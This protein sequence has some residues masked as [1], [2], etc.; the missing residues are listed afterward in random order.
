MVFSW[1]MT[2]VELRTQLYKLLTLF[3]LMVLCAGAQSDTITLV[4][5]SFESGSTGWSGA[6]TDNSE[7]YAAPDGI[8]Y[9]TCSGGSGYTTQLTGHTIEAGETFTLTVWARSIN[10]RGV[11]ADTNAEVRLFY[12]STTITSTTQNVNPAELQG[13]PQNYFN[14]DGGN[15]WLDA[16]YRMEFGARYPFY[17]LDTA[18][19]IDDTWYHQVDSDYDVDMAVGPIITPQ[20]LKALYNTYYEESP[21]PYSQI[22]ILNATGSPPNYTWTPGSTILEHEGSENPWCIDAH[23]YYDTDTGKLWM[24]WGGLPL[25]VSEMDPSDG[26]LIGHP[27]NPE[28]DTHP[29]WYHT[30]VANWSGD[31]WTA[32][33]KWAEG[34][35]LYKHDGY[36]Y[37]LASY[38]NL[39]LNYSI[40][41]GRGTS[42]TGPFYDKEGVGLLEWDSSENEY[43]NSFLLG[44]EGFQD[45]PGHPHIWEENGT[46]YLGYDYTIGEEQDVLGIRELYWVN[47]WPTIW[48]PITITFDVGDYPASIGQQL[49]ISFRNTGS[50]SYAA[51]DHV[52]IEYT[53]ADS[54]PPAP[55]PMTWAQEP[56]ADDS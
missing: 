3:V 33:N 40:R 23:L 41:G 17:Q 46:Y 56:T 42:P 55:D 38:G 1:T 54:T 22:W 12:G 13:A 32:G 47:D 11:T 43:G 26:K 51:F 52:S 48:T 27:S 50:G 9:A 4:N 37:F 14:D 18:D 28:Y 53:P 24:S 49:G 45:N 34:P 5:P 36:W 6:T 2:E 10:D 39:G 44:A 8:R 16:G 29:S 25:R 21:N 7:Y 31:E 15:V 30:A 35:C 19:P 20:G